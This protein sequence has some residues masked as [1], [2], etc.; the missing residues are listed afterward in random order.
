MIDTSPA[1]IQYPFA[2]DQWCRMPC[3]LPLLQLRTV[4]KI[5]DSAVRL[6]QSVHDQQCL[7]IAQLNQ[8]FRSG[9]LRPSAGVLPARQQ[10]RGE[11]DQRHDIPLPSFAGGE[12]QDHV[13]CIRLRL[14]DEQVGP[15]AACHPVVPRPAF[16]RIPPASPVQPVITTPPAQQIGALVAMNAVVKPARQH[17]FDLPA[18]NQGQRRTGKRRRTPFEIDLAGAGQGG[19]VQRVMPAIVIRQAVAQWIRCQRRILVGVHV[20]IVRQPGRPEYIEAPVLQ[21]AGI[22]RPA[23]ADFKCPDAIRVFAAMV[24]ARKHE[25]QMVSVIEVAAAVL[26]PFSRPPAL[27]RPVHED[28]FGP[29][30]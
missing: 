25:I 7:A 14:N 19:Q 23:V 3:L 6:H 28:R 5:D 2:L 16:Q 17:V 4:G 13:L 29:R 18:V 21:R 1:R 11:P 30:R 20:M 24:R 27:A 10:V 22:R 12:I 15:A 8:G 26:R 9:F